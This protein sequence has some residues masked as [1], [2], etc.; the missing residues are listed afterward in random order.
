[1]AGQDIF[2]INAKE[3]IRAMNN[4]IISHYFF[5][6]MCI[7]FYKNKS[8]VSLMIVPKMKFDTIRQSK[9]EQ[10][11]SLLQL[12]LTGDEFTYGYSQGIS[13]RNSPALSKFSLVRQE[14]NAYKNGYRIVSIFERDDHQ[15]AT[16]FLTWSGGKYL[17]SQVD[18][19]NGSSRDIEL[20]MISSFSLTG[21][22]PFVDGEAPG[23]L[24]LHR[25]RSYWSEEGRLLSE[26]FE[27]LGLAA[28]WASHNV[29]SERYGQAGTMPVRKYF[30]F[31]AI[32]DKT[33]HVI[34]AAQIA[35]AGSWQMEIYRRGNAVSMSG[36]LADMETGHFK[37]ILRPGESIQT[38]EAYLTVAEGGV[39]LVC[40]R[41]LEAQKDNLDVPEIEQELPV[42]YNE[43]CDTWGDPTQE[44]VEKQLTAAKSLGLKYFVI[45]AGWYAS[46]RWDS[47]IGS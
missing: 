27:E 14:C 39:D 23:S 32:E 13:M 16:H 11:D 5:G 33:E 38:P 19:F 25:M 34:W 20:Q 10:G 40:A 15:K 8:T 12:Y 3:E 1:M 18:Y 42:M 2:I 41:L 44:K 30:P 47:S 7:I 45:D 46:D 31:G 28:S 22:T 26:D 6:D 37:K 17:S 43:Y 4:N 21:I 35:W 24:Q 36:G 9:L 29:K